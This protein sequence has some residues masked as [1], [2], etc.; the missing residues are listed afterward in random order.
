M[1]TTFD[2]EAIEVF[3]QSDD[4][5]VMIEGSKQGYLSTIP[6]A[7]IQSAVVAC[8]QLHFGRR[9]DRN[10]AFPERLPERISS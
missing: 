7:A 4:R 5:A 10:S 8:W 2:Y 3:L 9:Q 6:V 1:C